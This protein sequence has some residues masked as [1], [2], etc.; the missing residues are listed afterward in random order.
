[1][2][3]NRIAL[4]TIVSNFV[5]LGWGGRAKAWAVVFGLT[6]ILVGCSSSSSSSGGGS[7][8][9]PTA[10]MSAS[11]GTIAAGQNA[12]L[13]FSSTNATTG[14]IDNGV[15][16]V[17]T[18]NSAG[19]AVSPVQTT[20]YTFTVT[21]PGGSATAQATVTV[22]AAPTVSI[23]ANPTS[24]NSGGSTNLTVTA[25]NSSQVVVSDNLGDAPI[26]L[27]LASGTQTVSV[28]PRVTAVYTATATGVNSDA[29]T[30]NVMVTVVPPAA[31]TVTF[32]ATPTA[33]VEGQ[34][35][36]LN[37][38]TT[39]ATAVVITGTDGTDQG[40]P[41]SGSH[42]ES[43]TQNTTY[44]IT[45]NGASGQSPV[46]A[47]VV[48][49]VSPVTSFDGLDSDEVIGGVGQTDIDPTGA[50]GTKQFM[51]YVNNSYQAYDKVTQ[52]PVYSTAQLIGTPWTGNVNCQL[53]LIQL[54]AVIMFDRLAAPSGR[55]VIAGKSTR[56][57]Q[58]K[59]DY[60]FCLAISSTDDLTTSSWYTYAFDLV[61]ILGTNAGTPYYPDWPKLGTWSN[62][63]WAAMD[64]IDPV[65]QVESGA[66]ACAFDRTHMLTGTAQNA[67]MM[68]C[69]RINGPLSA[70]VYLGHSLIPA[71]LDG[72]NA[73][74]SGRDEFMVSIQNPVLTGTPLPTTST[75]FNLWDFQAPTWTSSPLTYTL[76]AVT[77]P[78]YTPGCYLYD[79]QNP[80]ITNCIPEPASGGV[81][82]HVDSVGDRFMP[83]FAYRNFGNY[84]SF[85]VSNTVQSPAN[86]QLPPDALQ[87]GINWY[88]LRGSGTPTVYQQ[89]LI[90]PD[91]TTFRFLPSIAQDKMGNAAVGYSVSSPV[92]DPG[93]SASYWNLNGGTP[94][95]LSLL[96]GTEEEVTPG[97]GSGQWGSYSGMSI[98]PTDD[99]TFWYVNEYWGTDTTGTV[100]WK[101]KISSFALPGC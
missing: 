79:P 11:P 82:Q 88:E 90:T 89:G 67:Q 44:T 26:T 48:V 97:T 86:G 30:N 16:Q 37:W 46:T 84:E 81:G 24:V 32:S 33:L 23:S 71:D 21:G 60:Y 36:T 65:T 59:G 45:V 56:G 17:G 5:R 53:S 29:A 10:S 41:V 98:D 95:E 75:T 22:D 34:S 25:G 69:V 31:P 15:G 13:T 14:M 58:N 73:P 66:I 6:I 61:P 76:T 49:T 27:P 50:V 83:R 92:S 43:P 99:C 85:L 3:G 38:T 8:P 72:T 12:K 64:R 18:S 55:W 78:A 91:L 94:T 100:I 19:I 35:T 28:T 42:S 47:T 4:F 2:I 87:T 77:V 54:D 74:P 9:A 7:T 93:I 20:T 68:Q 39:N 57:S 80:A 96:S 63:Y 70:G 62:A 101:T 40:V 51:E 52:Q 1:M